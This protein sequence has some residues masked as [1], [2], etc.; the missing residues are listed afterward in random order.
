MSIAAG[1]R[2]RAARVVLENPEGHPALERARDFDSRRVGAELVRRFEEHDLLTSAS[3]ISFQIL[4]AIVPFLLFAFA[5]LGFLSL[6]GVWYDH[7]APNVK[8]AVSPAGWSVVQD[9][10][11]KV[12]GSRHAFWMTAGL[13][14]AIWQVSGAVRAVMGALNR[15]YRCDAERPWRRRMLI[16]TA[17]AIAVGAL[18]LGAFAVVTL[19]PLLYGD[20]GQPTAA[21]FFVLRWG[22]A[23]MLMLVAVGLLLRYGPARRRPMS[24]VSFGTLLVIG[25]WV[26]MSIGFGAY[27][28]Y[29][30][31][32]ESV[33]GN[34]ATIVVLTGYVYMSCLVFLGGAQVDAIARRHIA[35]A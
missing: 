6:D 4:T 28:R 33:F 8:S 12:L 16:S 26:L 18:L 21:L 14:L 7:M 9:T 15:I 10:V 3:A 27:L 20:L 1:A 32:Y 35:D 30:A 34:L 31:S 25:A 2:E 19:T 5:L 22:M 29:V 17:L 11:H 23:A 13:V 24:W